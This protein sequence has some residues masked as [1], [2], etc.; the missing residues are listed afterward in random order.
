MRGLL[1]LAGLLL[2]LAVTG[3]LLRQ[4]MAAHRTPL[5]VLQTP[6]AIAP[7]SPAGPAGQQSQPIQQQYQQALEAAMQASRPQ[8]DGQ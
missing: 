7:A 1:G 3:V 4:Q 5:P 8:P 2:V 6:A